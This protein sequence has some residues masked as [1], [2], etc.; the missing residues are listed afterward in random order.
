MSCTPF[1]AK[2]ILTTRDAIASHVRW[3]V[4]LLS[5]ARMCETLTDHATHGV[6]NPDEC[7]ICPWLLDQ[8]DPDLRQTS[9]YL[10]VLHWHREF[11]LELLAAAQL[12]NAG[13]FAAAERLLN[14]SQSFQF[15]SASLADAILELDRIAPVCLAS[16]Q[17]SAS[18]EIPSTDRRNRHQVACVS[19]LTKS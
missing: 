17:G 4:T 13:E 14:T 19:S 6:Q 15:A 9:E 2:P 1:I 5:A 10:A 11:H 3:K 8:Y 16:Y 7:A 12:I 18:A